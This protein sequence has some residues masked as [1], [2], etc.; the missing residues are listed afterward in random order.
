MSDKQNNRS[1][2]EGAFVPFRPLGELVSNLDSRRRPV[3]RA[4]RKPGAFPYYGANG[5][6]DYVDSYLFEGSFLLLGEDGSVINSDGTPVVNWATGK[7]WVNNHAHVL[8]AGTDRLV[9]RFLYHYLQTVDIR[10]YVKGGTQ[11]KLSQSSLNSI[12]VPV[13]PI[14]V[15]LEIVRN[16]DSFDQLHA[17]LKTELESELEARRRQYAHYRD[18][19]L[20]GAL[21]QLDWLTMGKVGQFTRGRRFTKADGVEIGVPSIHYGEIYTHYGVAASASVGQVREAL[22]PQLRFALPGDVV[23]ASVGETVE[24]VGKTVA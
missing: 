21:P 7:I 18:D 13:P 1:R 24:D 17:E 16:L 15:Q 19:L 4:A 11:L 2:L 8:Q 9:L 22:R 12:P 6:Q 20:G 5:V 3:T 23:I 10:R 14:E